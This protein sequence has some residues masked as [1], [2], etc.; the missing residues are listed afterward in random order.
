M[1]NTEFTNAI[2]NMRHHFWN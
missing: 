2:W 1:L